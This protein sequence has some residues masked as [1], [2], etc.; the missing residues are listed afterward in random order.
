MTD[1]LLSSARVLDGL[2]YSG[3]VVV[4]GDSDVRFYQWVSNK[5][6]ASVNIHFVNA[7]NKQTVPRI[8][9]TYR[10]MAVPCVGIVDFDVLNDRSEFQRQLA[11]LEF[12][13]TGVRTR[14]GRERR[15]S[16]GRW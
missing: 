8:T 15:V 12:D 10:D 4:E 5:L 1:P 3:V 6:D 11:V 2:F 9:Q 7:D 14:A 16:Q 13:D